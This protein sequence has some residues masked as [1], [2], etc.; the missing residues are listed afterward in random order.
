MFD[1]TWFKSWIAESQTYRSSAD[2]ELSEA[3]KKIGV[4]YEQSSGIMPK[5][6]SWFEE[7]EKSK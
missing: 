4:H 7:Y 2:D 1:N 3:T 6:K 5:R